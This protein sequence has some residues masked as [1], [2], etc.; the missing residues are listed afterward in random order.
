[1]PDNTFLLAFKLIIESP[2]GPS[3]SSPHPLKDY[4]EALT[5]GQPRRVES[6]T[7][8]PDGPKVV[9]ETHMEGGHSY[10]G[11]AEVR[12]RE[13]EKEKKFQLWWSGRN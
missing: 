10:G 1:M 2:S 9:V 3:T 5:A 11:V 13:E 4:T 8:C 12:L 6:E 7:G